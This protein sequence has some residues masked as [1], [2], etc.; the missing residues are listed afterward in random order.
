MESLHLSSPN[1]ASL[2]NGGNLWLS[3]HSIKNIYYPSSYPTK[4]SQHRRK[5][6]TEYNYLRFRQTT[7][8]HRY[9]CTGE[10]STYKDRNEEFVAKST[11]IPYSDSD[12]PHASYDKSILHNIKEF[13]NA[14]FK[15]TSPYA[16]ATLSLGILSASFHAV[17]K[18]TDVSPLFF[19]GVLQ[20]VI[21]QTFV[22][23]FVTG[24][25]QM[26][27]LDI[28]KINKPY[29]PL[30]SGQI[31]P[32]TSV[33]FGASFLI[34]GMWLAWVIGSSPLI[35]GLVLHCFLWIAYSVNVPLLRWKRNPFLAAMCTFATWTIVFPISSFLHMQTFVFKRPLIF[36][37]SLI[38]DVTFM[39]LYSLGI[40]L[41]KDIP[42]V[43]G[44]AK[45]GIDTFA[46]RFGQKRVFQIC[47]CL[48]EMAFGVAFLAG[49]KS[50]SLWIKIITGVGHIIIASV[51]WYRAKSTNLSS[52]SSV[53]SF[54]FFI[55]KVLSAELLLMPLA[56]LG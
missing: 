32:R 12:Q 16:L 24:V 54:Y 19:I 39:G 30:A 40:A 47:V 17:D 37:R 26:A 33:I 23:F 28:D 7:L 15:L 9:K 21:T 2:I 56:R 1:V 29:L 20:A 36:P 6:Q 25:N 51:V 18:L 42:D 13:S 50:P 14:F 48:F 8:N 4:I 43:E 11:T 10:G 53:L 44:D 35:W 41:C 34:L 38:F 52:K 27:D 55:W 46:I 22:S 45:F 31:S 49:V 3:I 5:P